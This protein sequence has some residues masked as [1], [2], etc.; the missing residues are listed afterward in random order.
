MKQ[1][2]HYEC[3]AKQYPASILTYATRTRNAFYRLLPRNR[4]LNTCANATPV[5]L[6]TVTNA[7]L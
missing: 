6:G 5:I 7:L 2:K 3:H 4:I 1:K